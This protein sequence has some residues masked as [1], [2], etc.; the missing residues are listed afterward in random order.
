MKPV[1]ASNISYMLLA[2]DQT[3]VPL[4]SNKKTLRA[5]SHTANTVHLQTSELLMP[6]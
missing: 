2:F 5:P 6:L 1:L 4:R 3:A